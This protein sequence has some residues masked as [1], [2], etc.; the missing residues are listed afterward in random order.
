[1]PLCV[2]KHRGLILNVQPDL[3]G[4]GSMPLPCIP[5]KFS[6]VL[7]LL[8]CSSPLG[9]SDIPLRSN[10]Q[11]GFLCLEHHNSFTNFNLIQIFNEYILMHT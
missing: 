11:I 3:K 9:V 8:F 6:I 1:M 5:D 4:Q 2:Y 10:V 7:M